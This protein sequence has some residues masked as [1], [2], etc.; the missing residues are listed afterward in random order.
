[1]KHRPPPLHAT[2][3]RCTK[4]FKVFV[5]IGSSLEPDTQHP[6]AG[7]NAFARFFA[8]RDALFRDVP[9]VNKLPDLRLNFQPPGEPLHVRAPIDLHAPVELGVVPGLHLRVGSFCVV[10]R[11]Q[12]MEKQSS[13]AQPFAHTSAMRI[14]W[15][16][17]GKAAQTMPVLAFGQVAERRQRAEISR[18]RCLS[19]AQARRPCVA[20]PS[21]GDSHGRDLCEMAAGSCLACSHRSRA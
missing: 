7:L 21:T 10:R 3:L 4:G 13:P 15:C 20:Q 17:T 1:M 14:G 8:S 2:R 18:H 6:L 5:R 19:T 9:G 11:H 16:G 12:S